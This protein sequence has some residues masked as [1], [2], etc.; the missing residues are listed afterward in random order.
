[1]IS[2]RSI[3][4]LVLILSMPILAAQS[5][6]DP[7]KKKDTPIVDGLKALKHADF[8]V[9]YQAAH[10]LAG[11]GPQAKFAAPALREALEDK[12]ALVRVKVA[13]ALWKI[14]Q[15]PTT[16]LMPVLLKALD[17]GN[18]EVRAA[19]PPVI[20]LF[21]PK[22]KPALPA[23]VETLQDRV[24]DVKVS[25]VM[26][27]GDLGPVAKDTARDLLN[28]AKDPDIAL[29]EPFVG[30]ALANFGDGA[31]PPLSDALAS[32]I[33]ERRR[34]AASALGTMGPNA[35]SAAPALAKALEHEDPAFRT[36]AARALG[37]I[38][39]GAKA[40][41]PQLD[42][43]V[44]DKVASVRIEAVLATFFITGK[45]THV[46]VLVKALADPAV[47]TRDNACQAIAV[48]KASAMEAVDPV[49]KLLDDEDLRVRAITT[50]GEI[51]PSA[52]KTLPTLKKFMQDKD[53]DTQLRAAYAVWQ[54]SGDAKE[55]MKVL[56]GLLGTKDYY[57]STVH[58]LGDMGPAAAGMLPTLVALYREEDVASDRLALANA[59][60]KIDP[61]LAMKLGI[62]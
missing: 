5:A 35:A 41:L 39:A 11:L 62:K 17:K 22:A 55:T 61:N 42:K 57:T 18:A 30:A 21:G 36:L 37:K 15:T 9:R 1:M 24:F 7:K 32:K 48:M 43:A 50:L 16:T 26:A 19:V 10:T 25:V 47:P 28:L 52:L 46:G 20:A 31:I 60:K 23:L 49:A 29:M 3:P 13:E 40:T 38:G 12:H 4:L 6:N 2:L 34:L 51:G 44:E 53:G 59:I 58:V 14:D 33:P 56:E 27:L 45:A 54:I 8:R